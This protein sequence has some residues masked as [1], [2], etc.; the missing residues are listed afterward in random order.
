MGSIGTA[1]FVL[2][3]LARALA[4]NIT[5]NYSPV[6]VPVAESTP[7][8]L[9]PT[10][11]ASAQPVVITVSWPLPNGTVVTL[12]DQRM[13]ND[14]CSV[15]AWVRTDAAPQGAGAALPTLVVA[16]DFTMPPTMDTCAGPLTVDIG[17]LRAMGRTPAAGGGNARVP[18]RATLYLWRDSAFPLDVPWGTVAPLL[19]QVFTL[20]SE[21]ASDSWGSDAYGYDVSTAALYNHVE[22]L[23]FTLPLDTPLEG[24]ASYWVGLAV[25]EERVYNSSDFSQNQPRWMVTTNTALRA[26]QVL[27]GTSGNTQAYR[28][29][30]AQAPNGAAMF[31]AAPALANW[32][33][34]DAAEGTVLPF[35]AST[36]PQRS[37]TRQ[38]ALGVFAANCRVFASDT[39]VLSPSG[40]PPRVVDASAQLRWVAPLAVVPPSPAPAPRVA[41]P[42]TVTDVPTPAPTDAVITTP[43]P[44]GPAGPGL[45]LYILSACSVVFILVGVLLLIVR[46]WYHTKYEAS[47]YHELNL[48]VPPGGEENIALDDDADDL[49]AVEAV[50]ATYADEA[51][52]PPELSDL[53][54]SHD[55]QTMVPVSLDDKGK[56]KDRL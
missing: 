16:D 34:A 35:L 8:E 1:A 55:A 6:S 48:I 51:A 27:L 25:A 37:D 10:M 36:Q 30:D 21:P 13:Y 5:S 19:E 18:A 9:G 41:T 53:H 33:I 38:L 7:A 32:T 11:L 46:R 49:P 44:A 14:T 28:V 31:R 17:L 2:L 12:L 39:L 52:I 4:L 24:G 43:T 45:W 54:A 40:V 15:P 22:S 29:V 50:K 42:V 47:T 3:L 56:G 20:P 23:R 26:G